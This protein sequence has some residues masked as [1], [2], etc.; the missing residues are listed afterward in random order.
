[1]KLDVIKRLLADGDAR[2]PAV[3]LRWLASGDERLVH[4]ASEIEDTALADAV[5]DALASDRART[6]E[7][8]DGDVF[9][10]PFNPSLRMAIVGAV[11][12]AQ[13]LVPMALGV[14]YAVSVIDPRTAFATPERFPDVALSHDWPDEA[15]ANLAPDARTAV[16]TLTHDPKLDDPALSAALRS[17]AF[18][19]GSL[20]SRGNHARRLGRLRE[21]GF[22]DAVLAR[23]HGP[24]GLDIGARSPAEIAVSIL[25]EVTAALRQPRP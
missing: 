24:V 17:D 13:H 11:H 8:G 25:A 16:I 21:Q 23:I 9:V 15:L 20:G 18:Y 2:R 1:M 5:A 19:I 4:S 22:D 10:Q 7:T 3:L 12:I 14:G 6:L